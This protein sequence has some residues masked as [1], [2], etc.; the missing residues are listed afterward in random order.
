MA[1]RHFQNP[2]Y[3]FLTATLFAL[4]QAAYA[5]EADSQAAEEAAN[6]AEDTRK[7]TDEVA[8]KAKGDSPKKS[9]KSEPTGKNLTKPWLLCA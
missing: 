6:A 7:S 4:G 8:V 3:I 9:T 1:R 5:Q 2:L